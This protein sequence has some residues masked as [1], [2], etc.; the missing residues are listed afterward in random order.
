[1]AEG[2]NTSELY[3]LTSSFLNV[4]AMGHETPEAQKLRK[5]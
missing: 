5:H 1:M 3:I 4:L 2:V